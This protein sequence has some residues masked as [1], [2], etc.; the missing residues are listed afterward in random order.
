MSA[1][2]MPSPTVTL[3]TRSGARI[4]VRAAEP[5]DE[6]LL[7]HFFQRVSHED[8]RFRFLSALDHVGHDQLQRLV[9]VDHWRTENF[10]AFDD[11]DS[12]VATAMLACAPAM[13][14]AEVAISIRADA[15][16]RGIGWALLE[17]VAREARRRGVKRLQS[18]ESRANHSAVELEREMGFRIVPNDDPT[19]VVL[20]ARL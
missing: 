3:E 13:D 14:V 17:H 5:T 18:I 7:E 11:D 4:A 19:V 15:K 10:L 16:G 12:M 6:A 9:R 1:T 8:L 20:E 2:A